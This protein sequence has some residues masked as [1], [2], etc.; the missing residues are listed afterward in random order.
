MSDN[1]QSITTGKIPPCLQQKID[2]TRKKDEYVLVKQQ[3]AI[4]PNMENNLLYPSSEKIIQ[5]LF[6]AGNTAP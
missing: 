3:Q 6:I 1:I 4:Q 5:K 2:K